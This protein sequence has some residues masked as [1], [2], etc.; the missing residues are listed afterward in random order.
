MAIGLRVIAGRKADRGSQSPGKSL[1]NLGSKLR[2]PVRNDVRRDAVKLENIYWKVGTP[3]SGKKFSQSQK[4]YS[5]R[6]AVYYHQNDSALLG[7]RKVCDEVQSNV[8]QGSPAGALHCA[9]PRA[10]TS[11]AAR[12]SLVSL[13]RV[14]TRVTGKVKGESPLQIMGVDRV[15][16]EHSI[17][18]TSSWGWMQPL[19]LSPL[20]PPSCAH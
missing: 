14:G 6:K 2:I 8:I 5:C 7:W 12:N 9:L 1:P 17:S 16:D 19:G 4:V 18:R 3:E 20:S 13:Y 15:W 11:Q 10:Q